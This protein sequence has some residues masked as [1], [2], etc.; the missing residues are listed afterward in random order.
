MQL[1]NDTLTVLW[2][3]AG[4]VALWM[5]LPAV[6]NALGLTL[7]GL[8]VTLWLAAALLG[9]RVS[10]RAL[11]PL[12]R[13]AAAAQDMGAD[14]LS[15]RALTGPLWELCDEVESALRSSLPAERC[16]VTLDSSAVTVA[17]S[18]GRLA[19]PVRPSNG[20]DGARGR[21]RG[22][23]PQPAARRARRA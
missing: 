16:E 14:D 2:L 15:H 7:G 20:N 3:G 19:V 5:L 21:L 8:S 17:S 22:R 11:A 1:T 18:P 4:A 23:P 10:R 13:M 6:L 12:S 9:Q